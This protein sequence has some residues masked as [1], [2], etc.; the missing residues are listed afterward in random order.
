MKNT[1]DK[2]NLKTPKTSHKYSLKQDDDNVIFA[3]HC[4]STSLVHSKQKI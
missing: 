4:R 1:E 3:K 2:F